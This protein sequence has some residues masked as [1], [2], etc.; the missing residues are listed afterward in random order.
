MTL[1]ATERLRCDEV[2]YII[3]VE[4]RRTCCGNKHPCD[5][6]KKG[7]I[8]CTSR[9]VGTCVA[10]TNLASRSAR[11][12]AARFGAVIPQQRTV[13]S[14]GCPLGLVAALDG[15]IPVDGETYTI[16]RRRGCGAPDE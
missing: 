7:K 6:D 14:L 15:S 1:S 11:L 8:L 4:T 5:P 12:Q 3:V 10:S 13:S 2:E 9:Q 16:P